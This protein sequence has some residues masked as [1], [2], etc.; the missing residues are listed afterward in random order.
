MEAE[1][2]KLEL[3]KNPVTL[4]K[5]LSAIKSRYQTLQVR[6]KPIAVEQKE[7][8]SRICATFS[9]TMTLIQELQKQTDLER[10]QRETWNHGEQ[11]LARII[12]FPVFQIEEG[13][14]VTI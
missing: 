1:V 2:D 11:R 6:F 13:N 12:S 3:M 8:K 9:K 7:T 4:L 5:E 14:F 10:S